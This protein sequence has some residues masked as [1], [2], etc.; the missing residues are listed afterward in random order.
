MS[1]H[2]KIARFFVAYSESQSLLIVHVGDLI[3]QDTN[4]EPQT[5]TEFTAMKQ[6]SWIVA[7]LSPI[8]S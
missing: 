5:L 1:E 2:T 7:T 6:S 8:G 3:V 4:S